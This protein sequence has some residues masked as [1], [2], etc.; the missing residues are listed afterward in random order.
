MQGL[1]IPNTEQTTGQHL[2]SH[3]NAM[4]A[5]PT[6]VTTDINNQGNV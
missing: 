5:A 1:I 6:T 4:L 3:M 2:T